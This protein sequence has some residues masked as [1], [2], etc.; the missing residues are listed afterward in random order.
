VRKKRNRTPRTTSVAALVDETL[1]R[2]RIAGDVRE[3]KIVTAW[4]EL[5]GD[6]AA[7]RAWPESLKDG[8]LRVRVVNS[9]WLH[10]LS[11]L[12]HKV[13]DKITALLGNPP[14]V[15]DVR[16]YVGGR[17]PEAEADD[18]VA[19]LARTRKKA[20]RTPKVEKAVPPAV[21]RQ[22]ESETAGIEDPELRAL[23]ASVRRK[24][25]G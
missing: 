22:I 12:R 21:A 25:G 16:F 17:T 19:A 9:S 8:V 2:Y 23:V 6:K 13:L 7:E 3:H 11:M 18:V 1:A 10:E 14:L 24:L 4:R 20:V 5:M 15:K